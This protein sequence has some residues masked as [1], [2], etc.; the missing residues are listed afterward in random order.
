MLCLEFDLTSQVGICRS[1]ETRGLMAMILYRL[2]CSML[3]DK[4]R[5]QLGG[6]TSSAALR[7]NARP[8]AYEMPGKVIVIENFR[9]VFL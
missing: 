2:S 7:G 8:L 1:L 3:P 9:P 4:A 5:M 6:S